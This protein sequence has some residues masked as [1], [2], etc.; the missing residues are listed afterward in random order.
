MEKLPHGSLSPCAP[1]LPIPLH[2]LQLI[3]SSYWDLHTGPSTQ[4]LNSSPAPPA[5]TPVRLAGDASSETSANHSKPDPRRPDPDPAAPVGA[6][7][8][9]TPWLTWGSAGVGCT[10]G[11]N[12]GALARQSGRSCCLCPPARASC[13]ERKVVRAGGQLGSPLRRSRAPLNP[14][15]HTPLEHW[16]AHWALLR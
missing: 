1:A 9:S 12:P 8:P 5:A 11:Y 6:G 13:G 4:S 2:S 14:H 15:T 3:S 7:C 10:W 16:W